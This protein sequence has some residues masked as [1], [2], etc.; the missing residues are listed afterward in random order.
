MAQPRTPLAAIDHNLNRRKEHSST[1]RAGIVAAAAFGGSISEIATH[2]DVPPT[3]VK[4]ILKRAPLQPDFASHARCGRPK[5]YTPYDERQILRIVRRE[6]KITYAQLRRQSGIAISKS[7]FRRILQSRGIKNWLAQRRP[8][9]TAA[10][11]ALR[12]AFA[13]R[14]VDLPALE[15]ERYIWSD[16]CSVEKGS[17]KERSWVFRTPRQKWDHEMIEEYEKGKQA[18]VMVWGAIYGD[19]ERSELVIMERD[20]ESKRNGYSATSYCSALQEGLLPITQDEDNN[21]LVFMQDNA[22]IHISH[23]AI[24]WLNRYHITLLLNW[25]PYSPDLNPIEHLW[26]FLKQK[27][28]ELYPEAD[29]IKGKQQQ[30][31]F[32][33]EVLPIVWKKIDGYKVRALL[34][35]MP[36]RLQAVIEASGWQTKY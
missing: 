20:P 31:D 15:W 23:K 6:P 10:H 16:E 12:L 3:T 32:L 2:F 25:P 18:C 28:Y 14:Y 30:K 35:S 5:S 7:T 9:L 17:G 34:Q 19:S 21:N 22:P 4:G 11:A 29:H 24:N 36:K 1:K 27:I 13:R 33:E 26:A 8:K